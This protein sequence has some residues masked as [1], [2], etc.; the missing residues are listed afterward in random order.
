MC[1]CFYWAAFTHSVKWADSL[2]EE[3]FEILGAEKTAFFS[4]IKA[5]II[6]QNFKVTQEVNL[7]PFAASSLQ[8]ICLERR[9]S[10]TIIQ[11]TNAVFIKIPHGAQNLIWQDL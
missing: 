1:V 10:I 6:F 2:W 4:V 9:T 3:H 11:R 5:K 7:R 8:V